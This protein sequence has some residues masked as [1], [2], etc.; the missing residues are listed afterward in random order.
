MI[1]S[2]EASVKFIS[3]SL[4]EMEREEFS[5]MKVIKTQKQNQEL[6]K[7]RLEAME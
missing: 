4:D 7:K 2:F 1:P 6:L 3:D 5:R